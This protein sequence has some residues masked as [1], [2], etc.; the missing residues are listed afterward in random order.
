MFI[1]T[2]GGFP[3]NSRFW[4][5]AWVTWP[6][7]R[8]RSRGQSWQKPN[9][10]TT[11]QDRATATCL[12]QRH[13]HHIRS[14]NLNFR[15]KQTADHFWRS[16]GAQL[17]PYE[18]SCTS[19]SV[20]CGGGGGGDQDAGDSNSINAGGDD[21]IFPFPPSSSSAPT[22][23]WRENS[24]STT[25]KPPPRKARICHCPTC[26]PDHYTWLPLPPT[27]SPPPSSNSQVDPSPIPALG[28]TLGL[29]PGPA[30]GPTFIKT[31]KL[32]I[33]A[34]SSLD[35]SS[36]CSC[37]PNTNVYDAVLSWHQQNIFRNN[38][39]LLLPIRAIWNRTRANKNSHFSLKNN[40]TNQNISKKENIRRKIMLISE[41]VM[42]IVNNAL[43]HFFKKENDNKNS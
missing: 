15:C 32:F 35:T 5:E 13:H 40:I 22:N 6:Y 25:R 12:C 37:P 42:D 16:E 8:K 31:S 29:I 28:P 18:D 30:P 14:N 34:Q 10:R 43:W 23:F 17:T 33:V 38:I 19:S 1:F 39:I 7:D 36:K 20:A 3:F 21:V 24:N 41:I 4:P 2:D 27:P 9:I 11:H 26:C